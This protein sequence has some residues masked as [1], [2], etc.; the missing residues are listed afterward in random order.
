MSLYRQLW[1]A[2]IATTLIAF[3]GSFVLGM[4]SAR[5][6]LEEQLELKNADNASAL[7]L[8]VSQQPSKDRVTLELL[9]AA[10]FDNGHY[11]EISMIDPFGKLIAVRRGTMAADDAPRWFTLL[12]PIESTP[13]TAHIT[14]GWQQV[15][16]ISVVSHAGF[17]YREL[18]RNTRQLFSWFIFAGLATGSLATLVVRRLHRPLGSVVAQAEA[19]GERRFV[20]IPTPGV[21]ELDSL[22]GAMNSMV[23]RLKSMF[24][25]QASRI[26]DL[27]RKANYDPLTGLANRS[28][29]E[30]RLRAAL[31]SHELAERGSLLLIRVPDLP[32]LNRELGR[33]AVDELLRKVGHAITVATKEDEDWFAARL[34]GADF[35]VLLPGRPDGS[36]AAEMILAHLR[37]LIPIEPGIDTI[38]Q[39]GVGSY[40]FGMSIGAVLARAD[41]ALAAAEAIGGNNWQAARDEDSAFQP[42][43]STDWTRQIRNIIAAGRI[44]LA[45]YPARTTSGQLYHDELMLRVQANE[46]D[47][48]IT[49]GQ[50]MPMASRVRLTGE[51]DLAMIDLALNRIRTNPGPVAVN[52][53]AESAESDSFRVTLLRRLHSASAAGLIAL[54]VS[55][56]GLFRHF[57]AVRS[58][59]EAVAGSGCGFGVEHAG[60]RFAQMSGLQELGLDYLKID[61]SFIT[62]IDSNPENRSFL[63]GLISIAHG[64]GMQVLAEGVRNEAELAAVIALGFDGATGPAI[65]NRF[66]A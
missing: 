39:I 42:D 28:Y 64:M 62:G 30:N 46:A 20:T 10:Q 55:E 35:A 65:T 37:R 3:S 11:Q 44:R 36:L 12:F 9:V 40:A 45:S 43:N 56:Q 52:I 51:L 66:P 15:G 60:R 54:E 17:A 16:T 5:K 23:T 48:W 47:S 8:S 14:N 21:P 4:F 34:N 32:D 27:R 6:Y 19:I 38:A 2:V 29:F 59:R 13:G 49:A 58:L 7:A 25:E 31:E 18:W 53:S 50:I 63:A 33:K 24:D 26:E 22:A 57:T 41:R 1:I 61:A